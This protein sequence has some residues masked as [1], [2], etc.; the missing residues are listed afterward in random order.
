MLSEEEEDKDEEDEEGAPSQY[1]LLAARKRQAAAADPR[2]VCGVSLSMR[3]MRIPSLHALRLLACRHAP[4]LTRAR[5]LARVARVR[6]TRNCVRLQPRHAQA[7]PRRR[8]R[9][10]RRRSRGGRLPHQRRAPPLRPLRRAPPQEGGA[11]RLH[12]G[13]THK[14]QSA[15]FCV[16]AMRLHSHAFTRI[17]THSRAYRPQPEDV[18]RKLGEATLLYSAADYAGAAALL[19]EVIRLAPTVPDAYALLSSVHEAR[20]AHRRALDF[21]MIGA[22]LSPR[23]GGAWRSLAERAVALGDAR[24]GIYCLTRVLRVLPGDPHARWDRAMLYAE[25][26]EHR[27]ALSG[28]EHLARSR[29]DDADVA[30]AAAKLHHTLGAPGRAAEL[31][32]GFMGAHAACADATLVNVLGEL[33]LELGRYDD[34]LALLAQ[35]ESL[36]AA[37]GPLPLDLSVKGAIAHAHRGEPEAAEA[38]L[39]ELEA[40]VRCARCTFRF[41]A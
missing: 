5:M 16:F 6:H 18:S 7:R 21:A 15:F 33:L 1:D 30:R 2:H 9:R 23:D 13:T 4:L 19:S 17:L 22:H 37:D 20:G 39:A 34:V 38:A 31:L 32:S 27:K 8:G 10:R 24:T 35:A 29:P 40:A 26:G 25:V 28:V 41:F 11:H 36:F 12:H 3:T 14:Q